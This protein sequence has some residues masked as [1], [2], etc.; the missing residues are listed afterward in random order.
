MT[1]D[2]PLLLEQARALT[3][4]E[5]NSLAN[6]SNLS[7]LLYD[8]LDDVN[9]VGVYLLREGQLVLGPFQGRSACVRIEMGKG[10]CGTAVAEN[11]ILRVADVHSFAGHIAC[12]AASES[13]IVLPL[14]AGSH[15]IGVLD[16]DSPLRDRFSSD[17]ERGLIP[18]AAIYQQVLGNDPGSVG[19][20]SPVD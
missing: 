5:P 9:W 12:D 8:T 4:G 11:R 14:R 19:M 2:Y 18:I 15:V 20:T 7:A 17:D 10:V 6:L 1:T 13:E 3:H 16:I